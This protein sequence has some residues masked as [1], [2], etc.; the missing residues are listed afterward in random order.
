MAVNKISKYDIIECIVTGHAPYGLIIESASGGSGYIDSGDISDR[1]VERK[2]WPTVGDAITGVV[3]SSLRDGRL[4]VSMRPSDLVLVRSASDIQAA[5]DAWA[6]LRRADEE[7]TKAIDALVASDDANAVLLWALSRS[8]LSPEPGIALR[9]LA[10]AASGLLLEVM[11]KVVRLVVED[12]HPDEARHAIAAV[13]S[14]VS[15]AVL[16]RVVDSLLAESKLS[17]Q[18]YSRLTDLLR[19]LDAGRALDKVI[20][21]MLKSDDANVHTAGKILRTS[22]A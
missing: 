20:D 5:M 17:V 12:N 8:K 14:Q 22:R 9:T 6:R 4:V 18:E 11:D 15:T 19:R 21:T 10:N 2:D 3:M 7:Y 16:S 1:P 13:G